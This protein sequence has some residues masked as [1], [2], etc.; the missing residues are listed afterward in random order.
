MVV[1]FFGKSGIVVRP[2]NSQRTI[3]LDEKFEHEH[4]GGQT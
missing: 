1:A 3:R 4:I 2:L